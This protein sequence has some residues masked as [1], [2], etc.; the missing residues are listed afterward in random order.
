MTKAIRIENADTSDHKVVVEVWQKG[1]DGA[2][3]V[4]SAEHTLDYPT[5]LLEETIHDSQYLVV[6][7][8]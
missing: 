6:K 7:E 1:Q 5:S 2:G 8:V 4:K 3:D